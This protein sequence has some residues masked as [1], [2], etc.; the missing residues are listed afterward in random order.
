MFCGQARVHSSTQRRS[1]SSSPCSG[2]LFA[3]IKCSTLVAVQNVGR[4]DIIDLSRQPS[5]SSTGLPKKEIAMLRYRSLMFLWMFLACTLGWGW[6]DSGT[7]GTV[8]YVGNSG[9]DDISIIDLGSLKLVGNIKLG[10]ERVHG[11]TV[12]PDGRRLFTTTEG[13]H[14]LKIIDTATKKIIGRV[15]LQGRPNQVAVTP[16]GKYVAVPI[17]D[18]DSVDVV[19]VVQQKIVKVLP[20][21]EPHNALNIG[22]NRYFYVSSMGS[23][24][25]NVIDLEKMDYSA[26][27]PV[28][29]R[30]RPFVVAPGGNT[31]YVALANL[32]GFVIV[33]IAA[34]KAIQRVE[35]PAEHAT[36]RSLQH[37][38]PD[39]MTHGL[40]LT[41]D[42]TEV[43]VTS[44][45][46]DCVYIYDLKAKKI[47]GRVV[48]GVGPNWVTFSPDGKYI[49]VSNADS[50]DVSIID[51]ETRREVARIK[52]GKVPK[53]LMA[54]KVPVAPQKSETAGR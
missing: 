22:S 39:T 38:T 36:L 54:A 48:T 27:I 20:I 47:T 7:Q 11:V 46:D 19:D 51:I 17:R 3:T 10:A 40:G 16:D 24:E 6:Q 45:M 42:G 5:L 50:N 49:C 35:M 8:L 21:K 37:E 33:E 15:Q 23:H 44:L 2:L 28:G 32:H 41:P 25:I 52:V 53:R 14:A 13:D 30:P 31:M 26:V 12:Q 43:W 4:A 29:G 18:G 1:H 34:E 9:G